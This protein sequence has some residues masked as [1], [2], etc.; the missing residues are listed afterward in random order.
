MKLLQQN[1]YQ[2]GQTC[3]AMIAGVDIDEAVRACGRVRN[4]GSEKLRKALYEFGI[5]SKPLQRIA[6]GQMIPEELPG[7]CICLIHFGQKHF[8][9]WTIWNGK[10]KCWYDP[11]N[12]GAV[13]DAKFYEHYNLKDEF[14]P[15][16]VTSYIEITCRLSHGGKITN[17]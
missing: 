11:S 12:R 13:L 3:V 5:E 16:R 17:D 7:L 2:C 4:T 14:L 10:E 9:H 15:I 1:P 8:T 6:K